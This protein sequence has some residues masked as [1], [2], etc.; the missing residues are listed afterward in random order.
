MTT[1]LLAFGFCLSCIFL[2]YRDMKDVGSTTVILWL[3][4]CGAIV[5]TMVAGFMHFETTNF[6]MPEI[7]NTYK[8]IWSLGNAARFGIYDFTGYYD[9]NFI[10][11]EVQN[12]TRTIP[13]AGIVTCAVVFVIYFATYIAVMAYLPR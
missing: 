2:L 9:V 13:I 8:L 12:P 10:G 5:F 3:G 6:V 1:S 4:M 11:K 7:K